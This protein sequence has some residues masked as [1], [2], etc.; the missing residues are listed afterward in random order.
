MSDLEADVRS[1]AHE[2][3]AAARSGNAAEAARVADVLLGVDDAALV[4]GDPAT[5]RE[6]LDAAATLADAGQL[7][8]AGSLLAKGIN[9][10]AAN[11]RASQV[12]LVV[13]F[14]NLLA[15]YDRLGEPQQSAQVAAF[16][17]GLADTIEEPLPQSAMMVFFQLG[18]IYHGLGRTEVA[19]TMYRQVHRYMTTQPE[20][21]PGSL[22]DWL[23][24]Y[25][26][27]LRDGARYEQV[28]EVCR[29]ALSV[30]ERLP[31]A[32]EADTIQV[33]VV[34]AQAALAG[35]DR[36]VAQEALERA[37]RIADDQV[38]SAESASPVN[39]GA[40][41]AA[42]HNLAMLYL[43]LREQYQRAEELVE[44]ALEIVLRTGREGSAE[45]AGEL[46]QLGVIAQRR[47]DLEAAER[48]YLEAVGVY[49]RAPDTR[50]AE[51]SDFL[52]DLGMLRLRVGRPAE[53]VAPF[54]RATELR[55]DE[56]EVRLADALSNLATAHFEAGELQA[57]SR[58]F[59][60]AVDL[61]L[62]AAS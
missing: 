48:R 1:L 43:D 37:V 16:I 55:S 38:R 31:G 25:A 11:P 40:A 34:L 18:R 39:Q 30:H 15:V 23:V 54:R 33:L 59:E 52:T 56:G 45:H 17:G 20:V 3:V 36:P 24:H 9:A 53:A 47:G 10:L 29:L 21:G 4:G 12:E 62:Q 50:P 27:V 6:L 8:P 44:R 41:G 58:E 60:R 13:P 49:E 46:G 19:L 26:G 51:F 35:G 28:I 42:Y 5:I 32:E 61:R 22:Y 14:N 7:E 2:L 57:A